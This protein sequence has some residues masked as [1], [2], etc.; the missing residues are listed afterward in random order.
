VT[1]VSACV[2]SLSFV[3][4]SCM[5]WLQNITFETYFVHILYMSFYVNCVLTNLQYMLLV[6]SLPSVMKLNELYSSPFFSSLLELYC[7]SIHLILVMTS[8][9]CAEI[10]I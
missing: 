3:S 8:Y 9:V 7:C 5:S 1:S 4:F 10:H 6:I 2:L